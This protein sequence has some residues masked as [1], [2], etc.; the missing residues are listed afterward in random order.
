[1][2]QQTDPV[3][4]LFAESPQIET[5]RLILRPLEMSDDEAVYA[6]GRDPEVTRHVIF[7]THKSIDDAR[8]F[9]AS[10]QESRT[11]GIGTNWAL[12]DRSTNFLFGSIGLHHYDE[13]HKRIEVGY[14]LAATHWNQGYGTEALSA[15]IDLIFRK[16]DINRI[17]ANCYLPNVGSARVMEK[18]GMRYEGTLRERVVIKGVKQDL[19]MYA[20]LRS[21]HA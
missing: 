9:L 1:M 16:T 5:E 13:E 18:A 12:I 8:T 6:Y 4:L 14:A 7:E 3:R 19:K 20:I 15:V 10:V 2:S 17:E 11:K 21:D